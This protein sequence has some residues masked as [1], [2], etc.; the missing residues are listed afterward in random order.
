M[1]FEI[2]KFPI[3]RLVDK[4]QSIKVSIVDTG[5]A[6]IPKYAKLFTSNSSSS[7]YH[8]NRVLSIFT[9]PDS[10]FPL[11][12]LTLNLAATGPHPDYHHLIYSIKS[13]PESDILSLSMCWKDNVP[14]LLEAMFE[15]SKVVVAPC[16]NGLQ[17]Y[18]ARYADEKIVVCCDN[19]QKN[20]RYCIFP[21]NEYNGSSYAVPAIARLL[22]YTSNLNE[23]NYSGECIDVQKL[24][25]STE[26]AIHISDAEIK[27]LHCPY[28]HR[29]LKNKNHTPMQILPNDCP[30]CGNKLR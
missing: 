24:F 17:V 3:N 21:R 29:T 11:A 23:L 28:C 16:E 13:L 10:S 12:G 9:A 30:Y 25:A 26:K 1:A 27:I 7:H 4:G 20:A 19:P 8:G 2:K 22:C 18:P 14:K 6:R 15:K 5:F